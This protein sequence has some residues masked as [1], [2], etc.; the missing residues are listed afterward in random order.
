MHTGS[1]SVFRV[2]STFIVWISKSLCIFLIQPVIIKLFVI[3]INVLI[4]IWKYTA[5]KEVVK[6]RNFV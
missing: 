4:K 5:Q 6:R 3:S 2:F 1:N